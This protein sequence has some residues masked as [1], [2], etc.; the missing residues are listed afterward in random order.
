M[1]AILSANL[2]DFDNSQ[3][4]V[5][6]EGCGDYFFHRFTDEDFPPIAGMSPRFQYRIPKLFGP[7]FFPDTKIDVVIWMD[8]GIT[9]ERP[10][11]AQWFLGQLGEYD[12]AFFRHPHGRNTV[13]REVQHIE[14]K[15]SADHP[16]MVPRYK[17]G[18]HREALNTFRRD[19]E[20]ED[21][22]LFAS[23]VFIYRNNT[24][25]KELMR[26]WWFY[27]SR[28]YTCDQVVLPYAIHL[29]ERGTGLKVNTINFNLFKLGHVCL[30]SHH[31]RLA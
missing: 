20:W 4:P 31:K 15:L 23:T 6:Q 27:Q 14:E 19:P 26:Q 28:Y 2:G 17:N 11:S 22:R 12:A 10:D 7:D 21:F 9:F 3:D 5:R 30:V 16:Y 8:G 18:L 1:L 13:E 25:G 24:A 29:A